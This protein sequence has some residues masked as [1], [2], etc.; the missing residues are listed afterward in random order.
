MA[1]VER[2]L[3]VGG[4]IAGLTLAT[5]LHQQGFIVELVE[6][7]PTWHAVGAGFL[8]QANG[9]RVLH[10]LSLGAA[11]EHAGAVVGRPSMAA[12]RTHAIIHWRIAV[13]AQGSPRRAA[14]HSPRESPVQ[15]GIPP[16]AA[17]L[18]RSDYRTVPPT[19]H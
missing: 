5:A 9:M 7:N 15:G 14:G 18:R 12:L 16:F 6:R 1:D 10:T 11:F 3:I 2:I 13:L 19:E 4:G 8:V 17:H